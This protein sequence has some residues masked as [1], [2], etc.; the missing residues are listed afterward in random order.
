MRLICITLFCLIALVHSAAAAPA[1][2]TKKKID[3]TEESIGVLDAT[4]GGLA[5]DMWYG[6]DGGAIIS[7]L[8]ALPSVTHSPAMKQL[9][10]RVLLT[11]ARP[12]AGLPEDKSMVDIRLKHIV[13]LGV[14]KSLDD[15][16]ALMPPEKKNEATEQTR[17]A[18]LLR[19]KDYATGCA[20]VTEGIQRY[21]S[22]FWPRANVLCLAVQGKYDE[23]E[24]ALKLLEEIEKKPILLTCC[25]IPYRTLLER[26]K[27]RTPDEPTSPLPAIETENILEI[28][29]LLAAGFSL[30]A[31]N[32][33]LMVENMGLLYPMMVMGKS[34]RAEWKPDQIEAWWKTPHS[35]SETTKAA[36]ALRSFVLMESLGL[37]LPPAAWQP[38]PLRDIPSPDPTSP[39]SALIAKL[40]KAASEKKI[41]ETALLA[42]IALG[43]NGPGKADAY[44]AARV[45]RALN[46]VG[47]KDEAEHIATEAIYYFEPKNE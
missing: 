35:L 46:R 32:H 47:L 23:A 3:L 27:A 38:L 34:Y 33:A 43:E 22:N 45:I 13:Q 42:L 11:K 41:G 26:I 20:A 21:Q 16:I 18:A 31:A 10:Q 15:F 19:A 25:N 12:P 5:D 17:V 44:T 9:M 2:D 7:L 14:G 29:M 36:Y 37:R 8:E 4:N 24:L 30:P 1:K 28:P 39:L 6:S 40:D